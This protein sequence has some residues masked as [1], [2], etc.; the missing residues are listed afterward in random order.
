MNQNLYHL[1]EADPGAV[2]LG[3]GNAVTVDSAD[4]N[5]ADKVG[6]TFYFGKQ[7]LGGPA[8]PLGLAPG[9]TE[10]M[11]FT[12]VD[13][14]YVASAN[15]QGVITN[16]GIEAYV[17]VG[18]GIT[19]ATFLYNGGP[20]L[21]GPP[22]AVGY[23]LEVIGGNYAATVS[24][25]TFVTNVIADPTQPVEM[26]LVTTDGKNFTIY[27][28][29]NKIMTFPATLIA[30]G[31]T[32]TFSLGNFEGNFIAPPDYSGVIDEARTFLIGPAPFDPNND[33]GA[34]AAS[35]I[36]EPTSLILGEIAIP[37]ALALW[38]HN[39]RRT[40]KVTCPARSRG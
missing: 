22:P 7:M 9:S 15:L 34:P 1:G 17:V 16:F 19:D 2:P 37:F 8:T 27:I 29:R 5:N 31:P 6:L 13:S 39:H 35:L 24:G 3:P 28:Q 11:E 14:R 4:S 40:F 18:K 12:N 10:A 38:W 33:L 20:G 36:P 26:A 23:G 25:S 30:P 21:P 32:D